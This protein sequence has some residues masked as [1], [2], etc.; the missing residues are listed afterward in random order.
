MNL[1]IPKVGPDKSIR[2]TMEEINRH[3]LG[4]AFIVDKED[5]LLGLVTD[6]DIRRALL[7]GVSLN[8]KISKIMNK[9]PIKIYNFW[10]KEEVKRYLESPEVRKRVPKFKALIVP[11]LTEDNR[12]IGIRA[13]YRD[14]NK[15]EYII[16]YST[17]EVRSPQKVL[18]IGGAGYIGSVLVRM[19]LE[20]GYRVKVMDNLLYGDHGIK[21]LYGRE[22]FEFFKGDLTNIDDAL[23]AMNDVDAVIHLAGI[24]GDPAS[25]I[26]PKDT[27]KINYFSTRV[28]RDIAKYLGVSKFIFASSCSVYGFREGIC[29]EETEPNPLSLYA[30]TKLMS[31]KALLESKGDGFC[32]VILRFA[33]A[34]G[35]SPRMRFDL[36]V[37][38]LI[39]KALVDK[40]I[41]VFG[42]G[43]QYRPFVHIRDISRAII[44]VLKAPSEVVCG[45]VF[46]VGSDEQNISIKELAEKI[47]QK[48]PDAELKFIKEKEDSRS[49]IV[50]FKKIREKLGFVPKYTIE[51]AIN[52][53]R[54]AFEKGL[55]E[56]YKDKKYS[57]YKSLNE[58]P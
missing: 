49:Y 54:E 25:K 13:V 45:E 4:I 44:K 53:I 14:I 28:L 40:E 58:E 32:P 16:S 33:T 9:S 36:V 17:K 2:E 6:G 51:M 8:E 23:E 5:R 24:V 31:E 27:L 15:G 57:N 22:N 19:L 20:E 11:V 30:E 21:E 10:K 39:A 52:E 47:K 43:K 18:V 46:N 34:Y 26:K 37:N 35:L 41:T 42:E 50:S 29:T 7:R 12:I 56:D 3:G 1:D 38:L 55:I 48:I